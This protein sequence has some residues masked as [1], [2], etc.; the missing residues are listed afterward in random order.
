MPLSSVPPEPRRSGGTA[1]PSS[2]ARLLARCA[3]GDQ[4]AFAELYDAIA[5]RVYGLVRRV[6]RSP[7]ISE[8]V[9]QEV[10]LEVWR[11]S[12]RFDPERG[13]AAGW[14]LSIAH[15]RAVDRV[16]SEEAASRRDTAYSGRNAV[17]DH[18]ATA[19]LV[20]DNLEQQRIRRALD[21]L[22]DTQRQ[23][24]ELA[25]YGGYTHAEVAGL[26]DIPVGTAKTRIRDG[27]IRLRDTMGGAR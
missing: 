9:S 7:A 4:T 5:P 27:L 1:V 13:S 11:S 23:S 2:E 14:I 20:E 15:R 6:V 26:L 18:D 21:Q 3:T 10:L 16:R 24:I 17:V 8:E 12:A 22:T 19:N 25:F